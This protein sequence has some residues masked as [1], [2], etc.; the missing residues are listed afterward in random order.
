MLASQSTEELY[1]STFTLQSTTPVAGSAALCV[2][3]AVVAWTIRV[4]C[5]PSVGQQATCHWQGSPIDPPP[6]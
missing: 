1:W 4:P 6:L 2:L 3:A 5:S